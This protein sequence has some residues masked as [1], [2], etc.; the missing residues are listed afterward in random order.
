M[1]HSLGEIDRNNLHLNHENFNQAFN[2]LTSKIAELIDKHAP[3]KRMSCKQLKLAKKTWITKGILASIR[4]KCNVSLTLY[5]W[6]HRK[7]EI[8]SKVYQYSDKS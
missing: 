6:D 5:Q 2:L 4:K 7:N 8:F 3:L 1:D